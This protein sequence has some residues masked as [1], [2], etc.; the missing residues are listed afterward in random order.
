M[1]T[2]FSDRVERGRKLSGELSSRRGDDYGFFF[3]HLKDGTPCKVMVSS[4]TE[5]IPWQHV[6][7]STQTRCPTWEEMS[8]VKDLFF[9]EDE[10][11]VQYHPAK[12][13]YVNFHPFCLHLW[14]PW[15]AFPVPPSIAV[16]PKGLTMREAGLTP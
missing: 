10:V 4:G 8:W 12:K 15:A 3:L 1:R 14:K 2:S 9:E 5:D 16:G 7:V 13:D 11:V 6:S